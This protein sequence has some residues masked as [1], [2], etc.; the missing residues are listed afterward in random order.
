MTGF[1]HLRIS[2]PIRELLAT[3][4]ADFA[5]HDRQ[6][7][8]LFSVCSLLSCLLCSSKQPNCAVYALSWRKEH[9]LGRWL[10]FVGLLAA[11]LAKICAVVLSSK[12]DLFLLESAC[13]SRFEIAWFDSANFRSSRFKWLNGCRTVE[14]SCSFEN[15]CIFVRILVLICLRLHGELTRVDNIAIWTSRFN[16]LKCNRCWDNNR[17]HL[18]C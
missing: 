1:T 7:N 6:R 15:I 9:F 16:G 5:N 12:G 10:A 18:S 2:Q 3:S 8:H 14:V 13:I 17:P 4:H 11:I